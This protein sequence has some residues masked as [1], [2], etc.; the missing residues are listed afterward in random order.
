[1][2][3]WCPSHPYDHIPWDNKKFLDLWYVLVYPNYLWT[4]G[5][6]SICTFDNSVDSIITTIIFIHKWNSLDERSWK[7]IDWKAKQI[8]LV[9]ASF[10]WSV[11]LCAGSQSQYIDKIIS[12]SPV[13]DFS[14]HNSNNNESSLYE[15]SIFLSKVYNNLWRCKEEDLERFS[16]WEINIKPLENINDLKKK[17]IL[18]IHDKKDPQILYEKTVSFFNKLWGRDKELYLQNKKRHILLH[19][20]NERCLFNKINDFILY[21]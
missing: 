3:H 15:T 2:C 14:K 7:K 19:H 12:V 9:G 8:I 18:I 11:V 20:L 1:M 4:W 5:S 21:D 13:I 10:W 6:D 17:K 16:K